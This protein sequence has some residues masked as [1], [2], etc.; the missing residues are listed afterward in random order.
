[1]A[2]TTKKDEQKASNT[3]KILEDLREID[4]IGFKLSLDKATNTKELAAQRAKRNAMSRQLTVA[5]RE[6]HELQLEHD[7]LERVKKEKKK[8]NAA[9]EKSNFRLKTDNENQE[10]EIG[11]M[12]KHV[13]N[14]EKNMEELKKEMKDLNI[15]TFELKR[16]IRA[17]D[18]KIAASSKNQ[19]KQSSRSKKHEKELKALKD[20]K[21]KLEKNVD[22]ALKKLEK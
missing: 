11:E 3:Q 13:Q 16:E 8:S 20:A 22:N 19:K 15:D 5:C 21:T 18:M 7:E 6:L 14:Q 2:T 1:M 9:L 10:K 4:E 12:V 17:L